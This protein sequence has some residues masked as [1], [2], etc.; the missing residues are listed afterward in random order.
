MDPEICIFDDSFSALDLKTDRKL[1]EDL[2]PYTKDKTVIIVAQRVGTIMD[3]DQILVIE[4]GKLIGKGTHN[5]L[6]RNCETYKQIAMSQLTA[7]EL[8][9]EGGEH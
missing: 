5:E 2:K 7:E 1:R 6:L 9:L 4:E 3:A 8:K